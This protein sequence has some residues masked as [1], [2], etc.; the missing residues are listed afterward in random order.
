MGLFGTT[1][2]KTFVGTSVSRVVGD[3]AYEDPLKQALF[4]YMGGSAKRLSSAFQ[5]SLLKGLASKMA[6]YYRYGTDT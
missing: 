2:T 4:T 3:D 1:K 5:G 6:S